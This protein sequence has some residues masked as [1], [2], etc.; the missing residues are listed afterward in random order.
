MKK[1]ASIRNAETWPNLVAMFFDQVEQSGEA[2]FL[3]AKQD[4]VYESQSWHEVAMQVCE[5]AHGLKSLGVKKGSRVLLVSENRPEWLIADIA[6]MAIGAI[7]VPAYIT[8]TEADHR[9]IIENSG[10]KLAIVSNAQLTERVLPAALKSGSLKN[11]V[12]IE[13]AEMVQN[14]EITMHSWND[15]LKVGVASHGSIVNESE[16]IKR[17]QTAC[18]I[19]TSGTGGAPKGVMLHHG[20]ILHNCTGARDALAE[21]GLGN[22]VFLSFLPL[23]H[24]YEHTAGQFFPISIGAQIYYTEA[25]TLAANMLEARPTIMTAV[26]RLY[27]TLH[28]R[29][30]RGIKKQGGVREQ[31]FNKTVALGRKK[32]ETGSL[33]LVDSILNAVLSVLVRKKIQ[34]KFGGRLKALVS[35]GA[36][37]N[38]EVGL[39][40]LSLGLRILQGYGL[41]ESAPVISV[42]RPS[43]IKIETVGA[44]MTDVTIKIAEDGEILVQGELV[45]Q[46]YWM[47]DEATAESIQDGWLHTGDIGHVDDM[48]RLMITDRKKDIIVNSGGDNIAPQRIEGILT[49]APEIAQAM[50]YGDKR[51]HLVATLVPDPDWMEQWAKEKGK[52]SD[53]Q[54]LSEDEGFH[55]AL[56]H[57]VDVINA[58]LSNIEKIR[59]FIIA[60]AP[61][62]TDNALM[63]PSMKIRRHKIFEIYGQRLTGLY[64]KTKPITQ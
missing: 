43:K 1:T 20:A 33:G 31:L 60:Q 52:P 49:L 3:W 38:T 22:E 24:S 32:L 12:A 2:P 18:I 36:P 56:A 62:T 27:E 51:P 40:F 64:S 63:T 57:V 4:G 7:T 47:N 42:N 17:D 9:Y 23:S 59:R 30:T 54:T 21:L 16:A 45:M 53:L 8:N 11:I 34:Q 58:D 55:K 35:G 14:A 15:L 26:P 46:G 37:L 13:M 48:G 50:V 6:I 10:A 29:I 5:L 28:S 44:P 61:F 39:F 25:D 19:Y 41:T